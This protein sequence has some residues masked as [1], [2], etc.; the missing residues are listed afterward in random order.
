MKGL[1]CGTAELFV[2]CFFDS[3][4]EQ[5]VTLNLSLYCDL[6]YSSSIRELHSS[7]FEL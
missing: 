7:L 1:S 2:T 4:C 5:F 3:V 6:L